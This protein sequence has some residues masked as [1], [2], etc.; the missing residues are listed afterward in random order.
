MQLLG[1]GDTASIQAPSYAV[2][3]CLV[4]DVEALQH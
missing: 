3:T 2:G 4:T 1:T